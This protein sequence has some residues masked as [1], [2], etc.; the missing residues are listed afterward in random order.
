MATIENIVITKGRTVAISVTVTG[1]TDWTGL[2]A[3]LYAAKTYGGT[4]VLDLTGVI[5][6]VDDKIDFSY[7]HDDT[8]NITSDRYYYEIVVLKEDLTVVTNV[9]IGNLVLQDAVNPL[10]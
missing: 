2:S 3:K 6:A 4:L 7:T 5:T 9:T 10:I 8:K 1:I